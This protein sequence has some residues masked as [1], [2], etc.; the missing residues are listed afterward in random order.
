MFGKRQ[1]GDV[2]SL[3]HAQRALGNDSNRLEGTMTFLA[4][5]F[6]LIFCNSIGTGGCKEAGPT[7]LLHLLEAFCYGRHEVRRN[8]VYI[9]KFNLFW[10][11]LCHRFGRRLFWAFLMLIN[12]GL[13]RLGVRLY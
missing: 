9:T 8:I 2:G 4:H 13:R 1:D 6:L 3:V 7:N 10:I 11:I 12:P 5:V